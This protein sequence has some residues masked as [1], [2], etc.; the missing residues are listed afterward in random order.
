MLRS[1]EHL[2]PDEVERLMQAARGVGRHGH[3]DA[4]LILLT[5]RHGL[6]VSEA[7][8][9]KRSQVNLEA[10]TIAIRR[11]NNGVPS[12][13]W[14]S[15]D[16]VAALVVL[17]ASSAAPHV[18]ASERGGPMTASN[19]HKLVARAGRRAGIPFP[20]HPHMLR[21]A[22]GYK[23]A[24]DGMNPF[25]LKSYLGHQSARHSMRYYKQAAVDMALVQPG[26]AA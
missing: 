6:R 2:T 24:M 20:V 22:C 14:L 13:Q 17:L 10:E 18:F 1:R 16:E 23:M 21:H 26:A 15:E 5:Y 19:V 12:T 3:R 9:L 7:I 11:C 25:V 4:T 8:E